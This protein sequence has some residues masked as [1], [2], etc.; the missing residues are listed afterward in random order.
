VRDHTAS[1]V[2]PAVTFALVLGLLTVAPPGHAQTL[3]TLYSFCAESNCRDG[4]SPTGG[5]VQAVDGD[6]YGTTL[7]GGTDD[8]VTLH[9]TVYKMTPSG[10]LTTLHRFCEQSGCRDGKAPSSLVL[11][12]DGNL[13]GP[14]QTGSVFKITLSGELTMLHVF[15]SERPC[16]DG[17][18]PQAG[19]VQAT[20]ADL[21]GSTHFNGLYGYG[22][23]YKIT[24]SGKLTTLHSSCRLHGCPD[25]AY[26]ITALV[27]ATDGNLYGTTLQGGNSASGLVDGV[28]RLSRSRWTAR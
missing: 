2:S 9:S 27:Q 8:T 22:T 13:Y 4:E 12:A 24:T 18:Y 17:S 19:L 16:N 3:T 14:G 6:L 25:G 28:A 5:L 20:N 7:N 1:F 11:A 15:C 21:Y 23:I 26:P 10:A